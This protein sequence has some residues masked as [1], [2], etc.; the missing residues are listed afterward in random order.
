MKEKLG[1]AVEVV[2]P[3]AH[4]STPT[5]LFLP[6]NPKENT[7]CDKFILRNECAKQMDSTK[8]ARGKELLRAETKF[9]RLPCH[10]MRKLEETKHKSNL[11]RVGVNRQYVKEKITDCARGLCS[12]RAGRNR[13]QQ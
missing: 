2:Q 10:G 6:L 11:V 5:T 3:L 7:Q 1:R 12:R 13:Q 4:E 8:T 9:Q